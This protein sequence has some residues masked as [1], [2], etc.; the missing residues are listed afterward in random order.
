MRIEAGTENVSLPVILRDTAD[1]TGTTGATITDIDLQYWRQGSAP[2]AKVDATALTAIDDAHADNKAFEV[3]ATD[4]PG[5]YRVDWPDAAF[6]AGADWVLLTVKLAGSYTEH[7]FV[8]LRDAPIVGELK[9]ST[10]WTAN[11]TT[12]ANIIKGI[13]A[14]A[15]GKVTVSSNDLA[16]KDDDDSTTVFTLTLSANG[17]TVA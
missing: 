5:A 7:I 16:Y 6:A 1:G 4:Q 12:F 13:F 10:G 8:D 14:G 15:R 9:S 2:A 3:D 11:D 17:R